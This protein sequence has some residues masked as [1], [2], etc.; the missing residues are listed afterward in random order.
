MEHNFE[1]LLRIAIKKKESV[2]DVN[3]ICHEIMAQGIELEDAVS[4]EKYPSLFNLIAGGLMETNFP[5]FDNNSTS[6][7]GTFEDLLERY[8]GE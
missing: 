5:N 4:P 6:P 1:A 3:I 2:Q 8:D 7:F